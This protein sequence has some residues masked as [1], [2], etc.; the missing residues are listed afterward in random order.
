MAGWSL[1]GVP[2][3]TGRGTPFTARAEEDVMRGG[4]WKG[5]LLALAVATQA[6]AREPVAPL[7]VRDGAQPWTLVA[8]IDGRK[9]DTVTVRRT[10]WRRSDAVASRMLVVA[11]LDPNFSLLFQVRL[12]PEDL[13]DLA[14][15]YYHLAVVAEGEPR[16]PDAPLY[17]TQHLVHFKVEGGVPSRLT[18][19]QYSAVTDPV[20]TVP[21]ARPEAGPRSADALESL[22]TQGPAGSD[23]ERNER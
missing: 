23:S 10:V 9:F 13:A 15:G 12:E 3:T 11:P 8:A 14:D 18:Q 17:R 6:A 21:G 20:Q 5:A 19:A 1:L 2:A 7:T 16:N 22:N 4:V